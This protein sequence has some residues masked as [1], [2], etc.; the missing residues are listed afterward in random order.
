MQMKNKKEYKIIL[1]TIAALAVDLL[2]RVMADRL[3]LPIWCDSIGTFLIAYMAGPVCGGIVGFTNNIVYGIFV[4]QQSVYCIVG[5]LLG[6]VVG[7]FAKKKVFES[8]FRTMTLGMGLALFST[9]VA[10]VLN[11]VLYDGQSGNIW[12]NQVI[13][14]CIDK[15]FPTYLANLLG[16]FCVEFLDKLLCVEIVYLC[17]R[18]F[19]SG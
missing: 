19:R 6:I 17:I 7:Y 12:G 8:R 3:T 1:W 10:V 16:Q 11:T 9:G 18:L 14:L 15:G 13:E 2:G 5:A 4:D